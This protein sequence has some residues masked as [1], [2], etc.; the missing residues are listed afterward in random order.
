[1]SAYLDAYAELLGQRAL[2]TAGQ[3]ICACG[4]TL[5]EHELTCQ[6][7]RERER[8]DGERR[9]RERDLERR[10]S[11]ALARLA[12]AWVDDRTAYER[13]V[14]DAR[15]RGIAESWTPCDGGLLVLG[16]TGAGK[17]A[18][19]LRALRRLVRAA[20]GPCAEIL[21]LHWTSAS[22][23][24]LARR[25]AGLGDGE[26]EEIRRALAAPLLDVDALGPE[27]HDPAKRAAVVAGARRSRRLACDGPSSATH[28]QRRPRSDQ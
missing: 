13:A 5:G 21:R 17:T 11:Q 27:P 4:S 26:A 25:R 19:V 23:I 6:P 20:P 1:M 18:S 15:L 10:R 8:L 9:E 28:A 22:E 12:W 16:A 2:D 14:S 7:C 24:A 3:P